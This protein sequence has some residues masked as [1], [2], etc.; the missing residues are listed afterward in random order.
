MPIEAWEID[1][2]YTVDFPP[3]E[4]AFGNVRD[5]KE[6]TQLGEYLGDSDNGHAGKIEI[7]IQSGLNHPRAAESSHATCRVDIFHALD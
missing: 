7:Q 5:A 6:L 3:S 2:H 4:T 1:E